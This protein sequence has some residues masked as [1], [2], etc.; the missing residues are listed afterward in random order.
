MQK[1]RECKCYAIFWQK[2]ICIHSKSHLS[3]WRD[4]FSH[5]WHF[6]SSFQ[7]YEGSLIKLTSKQV[8]Y[9]QHWGLRLYT[10]KLMNENISLFIVQLLLALPNFLLINAFNFLS[11]LCPISSPS[12]CSWLVDYD[13]LAPFV[14]KNLEPGGGRRKKV[15]HQLAFGSRIVCLESQTF[16][17]GGMCGDETGK[18]FWGVKASVLTRAVLTV[19]FC[20]QG[21]RTENELSWQVST[22][23]FKQFSFM[24][25]Y[26]LPRHT[27]SHKDMT[28]SLEGFRVI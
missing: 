16:N 26:L 19:E 1:Y 18:E 2:C 4:T 28:C 20:L 22:S 27:V 14:R 9:R 11:L 6:L 13:G 3:L 7:G 23:R 25:V 21:R 10:M 12:L 24:S 8:C 17:S 5:F 15:L